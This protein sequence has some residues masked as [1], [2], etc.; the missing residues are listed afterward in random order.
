NDP[1]LAQ[2]DTAITEEG[3]T[4]D[5]NVLDNDSDPDG[6][7][8][9]VTAALADTNGDGNVD[10]V[11][12]VGD[13]TTIYGTDENGN[14]V[15]AGTITLNSDGTYT[16]VPEPGFTGD[17]PVDYTIEDPDGLSDD[18]TLTITVTPDAGNQTFANDDANLGS[19][20]ETLTGDIEANDLDPE[21]DTQTIA[22]IDSDGDGT[23]DTA[24]TAGTPIDISQDATKIG[25]LTVDPATGAYIWTP[26]P[27]FVGT[28]VIPYQT[29]DDG[30]P[31]ACATATLYLT[32]LEFNDTYAINDINQT[33]INVPVDGNVLTNDFDQQG[34]GQTVTSATYMNAAGNQVALAV[35]T[36]TSIFGYDESGAVVAAGTIT[37]NADGSYDYTPATDYTGTVPL[38][39]TV[40]DDND[41]PATDSATLTIEVT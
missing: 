27:G 18:A 28:A 19:Q 31:Q 6:D 15:V 37:L 38:E 4:V 10:D 3:V 21:G 1:P 17:A 36:S 8:V 14:T 30:T 13:G 33:P 9:T 22:L 7:T 35:G 12:T 24:P 29:C 2:D 23:P 5:G 39:Y 32:N 41:N 34:D 16:F 40:T 20:G 25:E 11:L 26:E